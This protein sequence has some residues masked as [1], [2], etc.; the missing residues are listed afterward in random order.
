MI[1]TLDLGMKPEF[2]KHLE[3]PVEDRHN[4]IRYFPRT[5]NAH[6]GQFSEHPARLRVDPAC[7]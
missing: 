5:I 1:A 4:S 6:Q 2:R 7:L 3:R